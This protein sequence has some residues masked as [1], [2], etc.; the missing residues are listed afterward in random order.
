MLNMV[1]QARL[2]VKKRQEVAASPVVTPGNSTRD[3]KHGEFRNTENLT[4]QCS[5]INYSGALPLAQGIVFE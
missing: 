2:E 4:I 5:T 1:P 3:A